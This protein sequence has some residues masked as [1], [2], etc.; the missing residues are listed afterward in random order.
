MAKGEFAPGI[1]DRSRFEPLPTVTA[2]ASWTS[3]IH[4]H[5]A[6]KAGRHFD[7][8]LQEP[9][10]D[11]LHSWALR[12]LPGPGEKALAILQPT[13]SAGYAGFQG[14]IPKGYG[15]GPVR[16]QS[17]GKVRVVKSDPHKITFEMR[18]QLYTLVKTEGG[19]GEDWLLINRTKEAQAATA[20][21]LPEIMT[22]LISGQ[23][24][25]GD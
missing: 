24:L 22:K 15:A 1:K 5:D 21:L 7:L 17:K 3:V 6:F 9:G 4:Q 16:I 20:R 19:R 11:N 25:V 13:H 12:K 18:Q 8:R 23:P 2:P 10:T 14:V